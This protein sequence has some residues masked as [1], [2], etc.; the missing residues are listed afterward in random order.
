MAVIYDLVAPTLGSP[1]SPQRAPRLFQQFK[2]FPLG[3]FRAFHLPQLNFLLLYG[4]NVSC[5]I[6]SVSEKISV[7]YQMLCAS[8][9]GEN[10][11][12]NGPVSKWIY[13]KPK[14]LKKSNVNPK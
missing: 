10:R 5:K 6:N 2:V 14:N 1:C 13:P 4:D 7:A 11:Q 8:C 12:G 3:V 9:H